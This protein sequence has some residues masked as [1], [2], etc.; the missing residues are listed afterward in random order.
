MRSSIFTGLFA[1]LVLLMALAIFV[2][3]SARRT[4]AYKCGMPQRPSAALQGATAVFAGRVVRVETEGKITKVKIEV[5]KVWKGT[6]GRTQII[7]TGGGGAESWYDF[8]KNKR[9]LIYIY[10]KADKLWVGVCTRTRPL[11]VRASEDLMEL[12]EGKKP[13]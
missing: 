7:Q 4:S 13:E 2:S 6:I 9:Y 1:R 10:G 3:F 8:S 12:G 5:E 11:D